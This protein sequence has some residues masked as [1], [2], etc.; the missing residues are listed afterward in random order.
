MKDVEIERIASNE[1]EWRRHILKKLSTIEKK[2]DDQALKVNTLEVKMSLVGFIAGGIS[3]GLAS[4]LFKL[5]PF[6]KEKI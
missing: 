6:L 2:Q 1:R 5:L 3:G 4:F